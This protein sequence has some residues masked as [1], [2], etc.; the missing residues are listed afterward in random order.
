M[1]MFQTIVWKIERF[2]MREEVSHQKKHNQRDLWIAQCARPGAFVPCPPACGC[3]QSH[4]QPE[5]RAT[6]RSGVGSR[7]WVPNSRGRR[8]TRVRLFSNRVRPLRV[9]KGGYNASAGSI[10]ERL[11]RR[12]W[13]PGLNAIELRLIVG[14]LPLCAHAVEK[15]GVLSLACCYSSRRP[16]MRKSKASHRIFV[17]S[18]FRKENSVLVPIT[19]RATTQ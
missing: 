2:E 1:M 6:V 4:I 13:S 14:G 7:R 18:L 8:P 3:C 17:Y 19:D 16:W 11:D 15:G 10:H 12:V 5:N 9:V